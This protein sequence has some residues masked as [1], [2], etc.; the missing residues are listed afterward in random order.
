LRALC[1]PGKCRHAECRLS[2]LHVIFSSEEEL[3]KLNWVEKGA[4]FI[5]LDCHVHGGLYTCGIHEHA[6]AVW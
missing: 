5:K 1:S 2:L 3:L 6:H 4:T